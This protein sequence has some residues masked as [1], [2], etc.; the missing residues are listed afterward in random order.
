MKKLLVIFILI[1][2]MF[3]A[4]NRA[5]TNEYESTLNSQEG[6]AEESIG[7]TPEVTPEATLDV[8]ANSNQMPLTEDYDASFSWLDYDIVTVPKD[9]GA[10]GTC[11]V[12][13]ATSAFESYIALTTGELVDLSEQQY[14]MSVDSWSPDSGLNPESVFGFYSENGV[15]TEAKLPYSVE[16]AL[17]KTES[18]DYGFDY[19]F[20]S[21]IGREPLEGR[22]L[23]DRIALIKHHIFYNGPIITATTFYADFD[24]Y[25][26]GIYEY[27]GVSKGL[28]GHWINIVGWQDDDSIESGGYWI[29]KNSFGDS[30]GEDGFCK[31]AYN[32]VCGVDGY[33][34]YYINVEIN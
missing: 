10:L 15:V 5:E 7:T 12:Y 27:D 32:D 23:E 21:T 34:I 25:T 33:V 11:A 17:N 9:Q 22:P 8:A 24:G 29:C 13:A 26:S 14:V 19:K 16:D 1:I 31:I 3:S 18:K 28:G 2:F 30:W 20:D 6:T 4:C